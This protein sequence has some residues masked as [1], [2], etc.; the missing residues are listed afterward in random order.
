MPCHSVFVAGSSTVPLLTQ[1]AAIAP[2][3]C[4]EQS[5]DS[6]HMHHHHL[7]SSSYLPT[8][9][10]RALQPPGSCQWPPRSRSRSTRQGSS[11]PAQP[12]QAVAGTVSRARTCATL[13]SSINQM[14][15]DEGATMT[16]Q[17]GMLFDLEV[18][19]TRSTRPVRACHI[20]SD[21]IDAHHGVYHVICCDT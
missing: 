19:G 12:G 3:D 7:S 10:G 15:I 6:P 9:R 17:L 2:A 5:L 21:L 13:Q 4:A 11:R 16:D 8:T 18:M 14:Y 1:P 20:M